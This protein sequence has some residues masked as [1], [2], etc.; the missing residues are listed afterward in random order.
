MLYNLYQI[1]QRYWMM[2]MEVKYDK[3]HSTGSKPRASAGLLRQSKKLHTQ[4]SLKPWMNSNT[5]SMDWK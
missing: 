2:I 4:E 3:F 5:F 1:S